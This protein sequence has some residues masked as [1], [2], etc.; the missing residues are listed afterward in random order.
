MLGSRRLAR[1]LLEKS[2]LLHQPSKDTAKAG[3]METFED[4]G[5]LKRENCVSAHGDSFSLLLDVGC[6]QIGSH[7]ETGSQSTSSS[8]AILYIESNVSS[9]GG[10]KCSKAI[11]I[12]YLASQDAGDV[13]RSRLATWK[14]AHTVGYISTSPTSNSRRLG[15]WKRFASSNLFTPN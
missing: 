2:F 10:K 12:F 8:H 13:F 1:R 3:K 11:F 4:G 15:I 14:Y 7:L 9:M 5:K 6:L